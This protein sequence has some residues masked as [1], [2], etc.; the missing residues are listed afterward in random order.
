MSQTGSKPRA[1]RD[2][3]TPLV[4]LK[5]CGLA[6]MTRIP[7]PGFLHRPMRLANF[8]TATINHA[9]HR[10]RLSLTQRYLNAPD[11]LSS[12]AV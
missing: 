12:A 1:G 9:T 10:T 8:A 7:V 11:G 6:L 2:A 3:H 4:S 5:V